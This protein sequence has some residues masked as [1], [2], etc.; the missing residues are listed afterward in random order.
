MAVTLAYD[1]GARYVWFWTSDH[2]HHVPWPEQL[3]LARMLKEHA[4]SHPRPSILGPAPK[5]DTAI[6]IPD[7][8]FLSLEDLW[9]VRAM[10]KE[11]TNA[12]SRAYQRLMRRG[13]EAVHRCLDRGEDFDVTVD[14]GRPIRGYR[15]IVRVDDR[16]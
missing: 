10:D 14:D 1:Q 8:Y 9:W 11:G 6:V 4:Q 5:R 2:D 12:A 3:T 7:G 13:I 15:R 16:E